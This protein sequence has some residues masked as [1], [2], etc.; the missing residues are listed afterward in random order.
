MEKILAIDPGKF[1]SAICILTKP[2]MN[3]DFRMVKTARQDFNDLFVVTS[4]DIVIFEVST[5]AA[6]K[7]DRSQNW[8]K[9][10]RPRISG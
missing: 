8:S 1:K 9:F 7:Y 10:G 4:T 2:D 5:L 3:P 6:Q